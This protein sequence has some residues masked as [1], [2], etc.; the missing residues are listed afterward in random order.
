[1]HFQ[2]ACVTGAVVAAL[3][4]TLVHLDSLVGSQMALFVHFQ[5]APVVGAVVAA[6]MVTLM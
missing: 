4:V 6:L 2:V 1:M 3:M 5:I